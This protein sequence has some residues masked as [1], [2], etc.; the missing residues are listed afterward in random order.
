MQK[1]VILITIAS[2][3]FGSCNTAKIKSQ[4]P[5]IQL[6]KGQCMGKCPVYDLSIYANGK[7]VYK[8]FENVKNKGVV[9]FSISQKDLDKISKLFIESSFKTLESPATKKRRDLP[10]TTLTYDGVSHSYQT[11]TMPKKVEEIIKVLEKYI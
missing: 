11:H 2:F 8:G 4:E 1:V 5:L 3:F 10:T 9:E 6:S 7:L